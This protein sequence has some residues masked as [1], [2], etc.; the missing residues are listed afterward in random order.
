MAVLAQW[1]AQRVAQAISWS[2]IQVRENTETKHA[3]IDVNKK[4][5]RIE[6]TSLF[7]SQQ[8][9]HIVYSQ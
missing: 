1:P 3:E 7:D 8:F 2:G 9:Y 6:I 5:N 4:W